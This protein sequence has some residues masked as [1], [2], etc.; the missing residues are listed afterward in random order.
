MY[1][2]LAVYRHEPPDITNRIGNFSCWGRNSH[3][4]T[5]SNASVFSCGEAFPKYFDSR[6][7][8]PSFLGTSLCNPPKSGFSE[9]HPVAS[10]LQLERKEAQFAA[11]GEEPGS[12]TCFTFWTGLCAFI[13]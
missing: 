1:P 3:L 9:E 11:V 12:P 4:G 13:L 2:N 6:E 7:S 5:F 8:F 10:T